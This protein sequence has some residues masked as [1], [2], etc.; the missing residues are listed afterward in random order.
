[1]P[2][3]LRWAI[4]AVVVTGVVAVVFALALAAGSTRGS[5]SPGQLVEPKRDATTSTALDPSP[6]G[7][8]DCIP[9]DSRST[10]D[11]FCCAIC[12]TT[13]ASQVMV[14]EPMSISRILSSRFSVLSDNRVA[15]FAANRVVS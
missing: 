1:M 8:P 11:A 10:S 2:E 9:V 15:V 6:E 12:N 7:L 3:R 13:P 4:S 14:L 5:H